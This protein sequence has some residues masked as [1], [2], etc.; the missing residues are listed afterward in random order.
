MLSR[1]AVRRM[2]ELFLGVMMIYSI[3]LRGDETKH[4]IFFFSIYNTT[5]EQHST[6]LLH[7]QLLIC[8]KSHHPLIGGV[9]G[10]LLLVTH[11]LKCAVFTVITKNTSVTSREQQSS[12]EHLVTLQAFY[13]QINPNFTYPSVKYISLQNIS[14]CLF[15]HLQADGDW[16]MCSLT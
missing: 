6:P 3:L 15:Y 8:L 11:L 14:L 16:R 13:S 2:D 1:H 5:H 10:F 4:G 12:A 9:K 7:T